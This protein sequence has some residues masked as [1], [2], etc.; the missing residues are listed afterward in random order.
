LYFVPDDCLTSS[1]TVTKKLS[2]VSLCVFRATASTLSDS[3]SKFAILDDKGG[4][5]AATKWRSW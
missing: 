1:Y 2:T 3:L 5:E 4:R